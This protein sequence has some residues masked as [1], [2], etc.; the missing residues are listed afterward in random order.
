[1]QILLVED[2]VSTADVISRLLRLKGHD[3]LTAGSVAEALGLVNGHPIDLIISDLGLPDGSGISLFEQVRALKAIPGIALTGYGEA[4]DV[5]EALK[6]GFAAHLV[7]PVDLDQLNDK[8]HE[9]TQIR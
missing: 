1:M 2:H 8:I 5:A 3:V 9:V 6:A 4:A 7:K